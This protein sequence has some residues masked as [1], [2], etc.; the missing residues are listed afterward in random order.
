MTLPKNLQA[1]RERADKYTFT[2][3]EAFTV[4]ESVPALLDL[5]ETLAGAL[6][7]ATQ[8]MEYADKH[9][10]TDSV[11]AEMWSFCN[12]YEGSPNA[13][14]ALEEYRNFE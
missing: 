10:M 4:V 3:N 13:R 7:A 11:A 12:G 9:Y 14:A 2:I 5:I 1:V 6:E 8:G